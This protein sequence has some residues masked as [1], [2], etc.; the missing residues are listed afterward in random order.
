[1]RRVREL[2]PEADISMRRLTLAP[3]LS[4]AVCKFH[5][6]AYHILNLM[7]L[8]RTHVLCWLAKR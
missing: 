5:P 4:R 3:P 2:F 1:M 6:Y 8:L 7:P